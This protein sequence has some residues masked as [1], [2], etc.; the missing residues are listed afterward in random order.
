MFE[1]LVKVFRKH[2]TIEASPSG[3]EDGFFLKAVLMIWEERPLKLLVT[4]YLT[5]IS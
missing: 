4:N 1:V 3:W 2:S 5:V